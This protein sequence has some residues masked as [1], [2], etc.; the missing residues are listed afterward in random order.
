MDNINNKLKEY[1][2]NKTN[3]YYHDDDDY[4]PTSQTKLKP[5]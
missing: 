1:I 4:E 3:S 2:M 5:H